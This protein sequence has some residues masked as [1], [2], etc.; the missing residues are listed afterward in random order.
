[1]PI[2]YR[3]YH[4]K[5]H[6][7]SKLIRFKRAGNK[8]ENCGISNSALINRYKDGSYSLASDNQVQELHD[9]VKGC[10]LKWHQARKKLGLTLV[11]LT[12]AHVDHD[13][14]NNR[15]WNL[16]AWCQRCHLNH[17]LKQHIANRKYGR[18]HKT[19][20]LKLELGTE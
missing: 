4:P 14:S 19:N 5:W 13:K 18:N 7:I 10:G 8:C 2:N 15:F 6:L 16:A 1:M 9:L 20:N 11:V 12:V 17:D 3:E